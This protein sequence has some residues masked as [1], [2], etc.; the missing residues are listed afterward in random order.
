MTTSSAPHRVFAY[1]FARTRRDGA[2]QRRGR[3]PCARDLEVL[4]SVLKHRRQVAR[5]FALQYRPWSEASAIA[6]GPRAWTGTTRR[7][8][9]ATSSQISAR[10]R[11]GPFWTCE[12]RSCPLARSDR[13]FD[14]DVGDRA[15]PGQARFPE[16][17]EVFLPG[18]SRRRGRPTQNGTLCW[19]ESGS[20]GGALVRRGIGDR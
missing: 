12:S 7:P 13:S 11:I 19:S 4:E 8:R 14:D 17:H 15:F 9:I 10:A 6:G 18:V 2:P 16:L 20:V 1:L 3:R 5:R